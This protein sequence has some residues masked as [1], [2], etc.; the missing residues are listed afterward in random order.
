MTGGPSSITVLY[1]DKGGDLNKVTASSPWSESF[2]LMNSNRPF[3]TYLRVTNNGV[4]DVQFYIT[5]DG[6]QETTPVTVASGG[7][8]SITFVVE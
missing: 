7:T 3:I 1:A 4:A 6:Y 8:E 5:V 2:T